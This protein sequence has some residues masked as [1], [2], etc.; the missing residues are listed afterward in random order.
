MRLLLLFLLAT[1]ILSGPAYAGGGGRVK[2]SGQLAQGRAHQSCQLQLQDRDSL[3]II[4][5]RPVAGNFLE[6]FT[7]PPTRR[8][9][10]AFVRCDGAKKPFISEAIVTDGSN[11][12]TEPFDLGEISFSDN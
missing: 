2:V 11:E 7:I 4:D 10:L 12:F 9:Y 1:A 6:D 3:E 8:T 5:S